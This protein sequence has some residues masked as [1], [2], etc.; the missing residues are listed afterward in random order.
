MVG[1]FVRVKVIS[2]EAIATEDIEVRN[3]SRAEN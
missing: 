1:C 2:I 3:V